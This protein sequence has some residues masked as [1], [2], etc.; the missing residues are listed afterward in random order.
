MR[1]ERSL[2]QLA[3]PFM[4]VLFAALLCAPVSPATADDASISPSVAGLF[5][6]EEKRVEGRV[7]AAE[8]DGNTVRLHVGTPPQE[9]TVSLIIGLLSTFPPE[10]ERY[11]VGKTVR[12]AGTI[13][14]FRGS[15]EVVLHDPASIQVVGEGATASA[16]PAASQAAPVAAVQAPPVAAVQP[17]P[18][19]PAELPSAAPGPPPVAAIQEPAAE[20]HPVAEPA[21][22]PSLEALSERVRLLE[23]RVRQLEHAARSG[24]PAAGKRPK[25]KP[26]H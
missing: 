25:H 13:R 4:A 18:T 15:T 16:P 9:V 21:N 17:Q 23:A 11:Y 10:P 3:A 5:V 6:G 14:S 20:A 1:R 26:T 2:G 7:N 24:R 19:A 12:V 8:R 22:A